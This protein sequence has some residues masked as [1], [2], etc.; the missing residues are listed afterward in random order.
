MVNLK[1]TREEI[2]ASVL[3]LIHHQGFQSTGLK[4]LFSVSGTSSGSFYNYFQSKDELAHALIDYKWQQIKTNIIEPVA[5]C[6]NQI[7]AAVSWVT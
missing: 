2:L 6:T 7:V 1:R 3:D 4:E 5:E